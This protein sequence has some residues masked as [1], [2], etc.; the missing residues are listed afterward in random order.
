MISELFSRMQ[1]RPGR[2]VPAVTHRRHM[3]I[4]PHSI[5]NGHMVANTEIPLFE[6]TYWTP[7]CTNATIGSE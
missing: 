4:F 3:I 1:H 2:L 5:K 6:H 7:H